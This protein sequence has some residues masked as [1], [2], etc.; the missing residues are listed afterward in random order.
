[1]SEDKKV[2]TDLVRRIAGLARIAVAEEKLPQL[3]AEISVILGF[4]EQL[5]EVDVE[6]VAPLTSAVDMDLRQRTDEVT[7]GGYPQDI[8]ANAPTRDE[9]YFAVPKVIE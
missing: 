7:D 2:D 3:A 9:D 4:I 6:G 1:M 5:S 8:L